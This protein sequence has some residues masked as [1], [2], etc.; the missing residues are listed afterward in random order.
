MVKSVES[1][2]D[3][4]I[5]YDHQ[6]DI[7]AALDQQDKAIESWKKALELDPDNEQIKAKLNN[8]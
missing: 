3:D 1:D 7:Y 8:R 4:P 5:L 2:D 6:G